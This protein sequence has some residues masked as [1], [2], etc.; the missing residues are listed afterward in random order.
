MAAESGV[1]QLSYSTCQAGA[2]CYMQSQQTRRPLATGISAVFEKQSLVV[3]VGHYHY[4]S[5][6]TASFASQER[7]ILHSRPIRSQTKVTR[8]VNE[9]ERNHQPPI[10][11][12]APAFAPL[13]FAAPTLLL[14]NHP[15]ARTWKSTTSFSNLSTLELT[16]ALQVLCTR[17]AASTNRCWSLT[18]LAQSAA[19]RIKITR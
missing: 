11:L 19:N 10:L 4:K 2:T 17:T 6:S 5:L 8:V 7:K 14:S 9:S 12:P 15:R 18:T 3:G 1:L 16:T 13:F